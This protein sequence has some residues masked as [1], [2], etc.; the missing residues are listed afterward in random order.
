MALKNVEILGYVVVLCDDL[1][2]MRDFYRDVLKL[3]VN[4]DEELEDWF[5]M[6]VGATRLALRPRGRSYDGSRFGEG[7]SVQLSFRVSREQVD[8]AYDG[9]VE[10][11]V[12]IIES[13]TDQAFGHRTLFFRDPEGNVLEIFAL[14]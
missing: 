13:P 7:A 2:K 1:N 5:E 10:N 6:Q 4:E 3:E 9:L 11:G 8:A 14:I 12:D